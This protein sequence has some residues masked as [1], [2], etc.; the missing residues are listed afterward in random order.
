MKNTIIALL[1]FLASPCMGQQKL[2]D[3]TTKGIL[4]RQLKE[5]HNQQ[6]WFVPLHAAIEGLTPEQAMWRP[7][8]S[9]HSIVQLVTHLTFWNTRGLNLFKGKRDKPFQGSNDETFSS[10]GAADW[11]SIVHR[12]DSVSAAWEQ[13]IA[14]KK[15]PL[16]TE[17]TDIITHMSTHNA[18]HTGQIMYARK[19]QRAWDASKGV[20]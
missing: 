16:T 12:S 20:H 18:Y 11:L 9:S 6:A 19:Q 7:D 17:Q 3:S 1:V 10:L 14:A 15:K 4:L 2:I 8:D 5:T 13:A